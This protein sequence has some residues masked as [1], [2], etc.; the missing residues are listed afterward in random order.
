MSEAM[1]RAFAEIGQRAPAA[2]GSVI[3]SGA[4]SL[5]D[6]DAHFWSRVRRIC[7]EEFV[8]KDLIDIQAKCNKIRDLEIARGKSGHWTH[9]L[10]RHIAAIQLSASVSARAARDVQIA[11][12]GRAYV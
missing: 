7:G 6:S 9:D 4:Q 3:K 2:V 5:C 1:Q 11:K 10:N 8:G 12:Y